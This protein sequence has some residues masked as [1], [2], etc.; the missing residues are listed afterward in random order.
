[1][2][3]DSGTTI[4]YFPDDIS[5]AIN[6]AFDP[7]AQYD[8]FSGEYFV[9]CDAVAPL[10]SIT[11]NGTTFYIN[12]QDM[13]LNDVELGDDAPSDAVAPC[14]S[15]AGTAGDQGMLVLGDVFL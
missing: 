2:I 11:I 10:V 13:I 14:A 6:S 15:G 12:P 9:D 4:N 1:M 5:A 8:P 7:P 3:I